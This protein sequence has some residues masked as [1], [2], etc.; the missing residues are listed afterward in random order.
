MSCGLA[1][2]FGIVPYNSRLHLPSDECKRVLRE[3]ISADHGLYMAV[4]ETLKAFGQWLCGKC[5]DLHVVSRGCHHPYGLVCYSKGSDDMSGYIVGIS[6]PSNKE[7]GTKVTEGLILDAELL[8]RVFKVPITT[9][10]CIPHGCRLAFS[11]AL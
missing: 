3:A 2:D 8:D 4:E 1:G 6:K 5:M 7:P 11:Q 10:K 9:V